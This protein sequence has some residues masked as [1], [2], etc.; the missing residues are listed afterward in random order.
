MNITEFIRI[1]QEEDLYVVLRPGPY[2]CAEREMGGLPY[3]L[4]QFHP[5][6]Y[7]RS[8]DPNYLQNVE[9]WMGVLFNELEPLWNGNGGPIIT[10]QVENEFGFYTSCDKE[11]TAWLR[12]LFQRYIKDK[13]VLF[14]TDGPG[15][16]SLG[17]GKIEGELQ[18]GGS[19]IYILA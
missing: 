17:C 15:D 7:L 9:R 10:V 3:W 2:I 12:D 6:I 11:Y 16:G 8:N 4:L 5:D 18:S 14:T 19:G 13:A 1:A